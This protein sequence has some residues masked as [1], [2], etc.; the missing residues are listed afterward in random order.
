LRD[1]KLI[2]TW[3]AAALDLADK[4]EAA[5]FP[6]DE[7]ETLAQLASRG[8]TQLLVIDTAFGRLLDI[9]SSHCYLSHGGAS[10]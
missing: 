9:A 7:S 4:V 8:T 3:R 1:R 2:R 10:D 6:I 5:G